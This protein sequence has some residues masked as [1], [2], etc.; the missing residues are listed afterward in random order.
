M[1]FVIVSRAAEVSGP[2][3]RRG[4]TR[5]HPIAGGGGTPI[6]PRLRRTVRLLAAALCMAGALAGAG[7]AQEM[8]P[9]AYSSSPVGANFLAVA[10]GNT[11]GAILFDP[12]LPI[13]DVQA[14]LNLGSLG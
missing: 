3:T 14:D 13:T 10:V 9:R 4:M 12:T 6:R 1:N 7:F 8:E 11:Q 5:L 2:R